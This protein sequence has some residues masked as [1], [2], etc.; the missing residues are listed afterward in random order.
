MAG[1]SGWDAGRV[2]AAGCARR[3]TSR[4]KRR[5]RLRK[6]YEFLV[7]FTSTPGF[8]GTY[9]WSRAIKEANPKIKIA[10]VGPHV[11]VLPEKSLRDCP[12]I[13]FICRKEF[14]YA[15]VDFANGKPLEE[16]LGISFLKDGKVVHNSGSAADSGSGRAAARHRRLQA[17]SGCNEIQRAV[18]AASV[19]V[20]V[21][22]A[23]MP[24]AVHVLLVAADVE[25]ASLAQAFDA[26]T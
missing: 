23:R 4:Q 10:F 6:D 1:L 16:I 19:R 26:T 24:G 18:P 8:P 22:H 7:L 2:A 5:S 15:V 12:A 3:T 11:T 21:H 14:D 13:D 20:A 25:R 9:G 17:R